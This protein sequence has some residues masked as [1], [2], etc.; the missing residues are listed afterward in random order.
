M[1]RH[2]WRPALAAALAC[3]LAASPLPATD[4]DPA[5]PPSASP[6]TQQAT[7][8][9][10]LPA[11]SPP[12]DVDSLGRTL[13]YLTLLAAA[14]FLA[15]RFLKNGNPFR[16]RAAAASRKLQVLETRPLGNRQ[17]LLV[18]GY[19]DAR[20]LLGV[21]PGKIDYLCPLDQG[22]SRDFAELV[23]TENPTPAP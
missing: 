6:P 14:A 12:I 3:F 1:T 16:N 9:A 2:A 10:D 11:A 19:E 20:M 13:T 21:T 5:P 7:P 8:T 17:F 23:S 15:Y 4:G 18:V 22:T